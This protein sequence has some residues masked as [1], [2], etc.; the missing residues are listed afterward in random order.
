MIA[1]SSCAHWIRNTDPFGLGGLRGGICRCPRVLDN[2]LPPPEDDGRTD[3]VYMEEDSN[4]SHGVSLFP[5]QDFF[6]AHHTPG[7]AK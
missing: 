4:Y 7:E 1:C 5:M 3:L 6:C 2:T